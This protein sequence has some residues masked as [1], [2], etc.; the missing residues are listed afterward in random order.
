M[1]E[2]EAIRKHPLYVKF[3]KKLSKAETDRIF[4]RHQ[5]SHYL[6][7]ARIAYIYNL[8]QNLGFRKEVIYAAA[9]LHDIGK[10][11]QYKKKIPH[12][13]ASAELAEEILKDLP[14][15]YFSEEEKKLIVRAVLEH[16]K[17]KEE[18]SELGKLLYISD[19]KS[20]ACYLCPAEEQCDWS[21]EKKNMEIEI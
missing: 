15:T 13:I 4:C 3:Y 10:Y 16:R 21:K 8:E 11:K 18:M 12:E 1:K 9:I 7:V 14:K 6:N 17:W 5:M 19:K 2:C 20:R